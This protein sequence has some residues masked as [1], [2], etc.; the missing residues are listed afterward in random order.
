MMAEAY[1]FGDQRNVRATGRATDRGPT[2][3]RVGLGLRLRAL[4]EQAGVTREQAGESI[5]GSAPK[6]SRL[7]L[8]RTGFK[9]RDVLDLLT[10]YGVTDPGLRSEFVDLVRAANEPGWWQR[11]A[12]LLP[13]WFET[14]LGLEQA[15]S[16]VRTYECQ[17]VPGLLQTR[18]YAEAVIR[19]GHDNPD[20]IERRVELRMRR[21]RILES[22]DG[23]VLW[24][25]VDEAA[26]RRPLGTE[27]AHRAQLRHLIEQAQRRTVRIQIVPFAL[28]G[29][30]AAG[31]AFTILRFAEPDLPD[32]VYLEQLTSALY[33]DKPSEVDR[34][35]SVMNRLC[36][37]VAPPDDT[38]GILEDL[39]S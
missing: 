24:V 27:A 14:Y 32:V 10:C 23:P 37:S 17:F 11:Y 2:A 3:L 25:A 16:S 4:R 28:G 26:L 36:A 20:E 13:S 6:I 34:Y 22:E 1:R 35:T 7:E 19:L 33:L 29:H 8:G 5:R 31:G 30:A 21:Q 12:D 15:A 38:I 18:E 39:L 9:Q